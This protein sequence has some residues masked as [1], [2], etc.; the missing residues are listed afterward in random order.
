M[1]KL[2]CSFLVLLAVCVSLCGEVLAQEFQTVMDGEWNNPNVWLPNGVPPNTAQIT[3]NHRITSRGVHSVGRDGQLTIGIEGSLY[4][5]RFINSGLLINKGRLVV[6]SLENNAGG[7]LENRRLMRIKKVVNSASARWVNSDRMM[8]TDLLKNEGIFINEKFLDA[9]HIVNSN[10]FQTLPES[11]V[12]IAETLNNRSSGSFGLCGRIIL[13]QND[14]PSLFSNEGT[15]SGDCQGG[16]FLVSSNDTLE[17]TATGAIIG[18]VMLCLRGGILKNE[19][20]GSF[21]ESC[22][23]L[24]EVNAGE[25]RKI[26]M[27]EATSLGTFFTADSGTPPYDFQWS[28]STEPS[29]SSS[30]AN[31]EVSPLVE[32][33]YTVEITDNV[34]CVKQDKVILSPVT[35]AVVDAGPELS[36]ICSGETIFLGGENS[37]Y[38]GTESYRFSWSPASNI[39]DPMSLNP[40]AGPTGT[41]A[42]VLT[43]E[44][45]GPSGGFVVVDRDTSLVIVLPGP[46]KAEAGEDITLCPEIATEVMLKATAPEFGIGEWSILSGEGKISDLSDPN[47]LLSNLEPGSIVVLAWTVGTEGCSSETDI[48]EVKVLPEV[49]IIAESNELCLGESITLTASAGNSFL[50]SPVEG[51]DNPRAKSPSASPESNITYTVSIDGETCSSSSISLT[52]KPVPMASAGTSAIIKAGEST[53]LFAEGGV[54]YLWSPSS[55]LDNPNTARPT[56]SPKQSVIYTATIFGENGCSSTAFVDIKVNDTFEI[57]V[58]ELFTP[59]GDGNNDILFVNTLGIA[60]MEFRVFDRTGQL[61]FETSDPLLGWDGRQNGKQMGLDTYIYTVNAL[62]FGEK[63]VQEK[64]T[65]QLVR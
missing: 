46:S 33:E 8:V 54:R 22:C 5:N 1:S 24:L 53:E 39:S 11:D 4:L 58:P 55:G 40:V 42:Y 15:V 43:L 3:V 18:E 20:T 44:E 62:T 28:S 50:W 59:N 16:I 49:E 45:L 37:A 34:G 9:Q 63:V 61:L 17:N 35:D 10:D 51:L 57:F 12:L 52:V 30:T 47:A 60:Q 31:P 41:T 6:D 64:G 29:F 32:T 27:G 14:I 36:V 13:V 2:V 65:V 19:G 26:C 21:V 23:F 25:G 38:C 7:L 56:A 48:V